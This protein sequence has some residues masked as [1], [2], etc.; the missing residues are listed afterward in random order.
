MKIKRLLLIIALISVFMDILCAKAFAYNGE[1]SVYVTYTGKC[2]HRLGCT[3]L[4]SQVE[5]SLEEAVQKGYYGCSRCS[6]PV[7]GEGSEHD[8]DRYYSYAEKQEMQQAEEKKEKEKIKQEEKEEIKLEEKDGTKEIEQKKS[9]SV[10]YVIVLIVG[11]TVILVLRTR[12]K[13][14]K[15]MAL[16][17]A[18]CCGDLPGGMPGMPFGTVIGDDR[19][20]SQVGKNGW[21]P[22]YTFYVASSGSVFHKIPNCSRGAHYPVHAIN[23]GNRRPC[24]KC[25][26]VLP[27]LKWFNSCKDI[28]NVGIDEKVGI[29]KEKTEI[30]SPKKADYFLRVKIGMTQKGKPIY[31]I[32]YANNPEELREKAF[33]AK[34]PQM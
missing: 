12:A 33:N 21:G 23:V 6:P 8:T 18:R 9:I 7:L 19:L 1:I 30:Y 31:K 17:E 5:L 14:K 32:V 4:D 22:M 20:P 25:R 2:Y 29:Y 24:K 10:T 15:E 11:A 13:T 16:H 26:P 3:Y 34:F 27:N 28:K